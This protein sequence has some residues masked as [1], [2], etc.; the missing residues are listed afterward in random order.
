M[1]NELYQRIRGVLIGGA[2]GDAYGMPTE[3]F[4]RR[5]LM[6]KFPEGIHEMLHSLNE[7]SFIQRDFQAGTVTDDT[8]NT[9]MILNSIVSN[10]GSINTQQYIDSLIDWIK[11]SDDAQLVCGPSTLKAV[12]AI[13]AGGSFK[14]TGFGSTTN[15]AAMKIAP[16][17]IV[18]D[19]MNLNDLM[20]KVYQICLPTHNTAIA[21]SGACVI[22]ACV[23]YA[24]SGG[25]NIEELWNLAIRVADE[26]KNLGA[27]FPSPSLTWRISHARNIVKNTDC[28]DAI[29]RIVNE[30]GTGVETIEAIPSVLAVVH[31]AQ[32]DPLKAAQISA[33]L[34]ADTDTIGAMS[35]SICGGMSAT[36]KEEDISQLE[37]VNNIDFNRLTSDIYQYCPFDK[38]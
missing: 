3:F 37:K 33:T 19:Y 24:I 27:E 16:I 21:V 11:K 26:S 30:I 17:G 4:T 12:E 18:S 13:Q 38:N 9:V 25:N 10:N 32:G 31:L 29:E 34:G 1:D 28:N 35:A 14:K 20:E 15:G 2:L 36:F 7:S 6:E 23:S 5:Q 8:I 22:A